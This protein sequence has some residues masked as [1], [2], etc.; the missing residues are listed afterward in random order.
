MFERLT[1]KVAYLRQHYFVKNAAV[2]QSGTVLGN[3]LQAVVGIFLARLL[4]PEL[5]G[6]YVLAFSLAGLISVVFGIGVQEAVL[7]VLG[8]AYQENDRVTAKD[9]LTFMLKIAV[10]DFILVLASLPALLW[11]AQRMYD[12]R[13]IGLYA[14]VVV[15]A[16]VISTAFLSLVSVALQVT[17]QIRTLTFLTVG[18]QILRLVLSVA[19]VL[20][21]LKVA[22]AALGHFWGAVIVAIISLGIWRRISRQDSFFPSIWKLLAHWRKVSVRRLWW[23]YSF[24]VNFDRGIGNLYQILP[25]FML[26]IFMP[27]SEVTFFKLAFGYLNLAL[28]LLAPISVLLNSEFPHTLAEDPTKIRSRFVKVSGYATL[29]SLVITIGAVLFSPIMFKILYGEAFAPSIWYTYGLAVYAGLMGIGVGLGPLWRA[30]R[31]IRTSIV[32]NV[33]TLMVGIPTGYWLIKYWHGWG[34]VVMVTA[35]YTVSH[36]AS[37]LYLLGLTS[38]TSN[39][40]KELVN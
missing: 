16:A 2:L 34:A 28:S 3:L 33:A 11:I 6:I 21:G 5:Y 22:G 10:V 9:F 12:S 20:G 4:Q 13:A 38:T 29:L 32:I 17:R 27:P 24:W 35:W 14:W 40:A 1:D 37:F 8:K 36:F 23:G 31:R 7:A 25:V 39:K 26:G 19:L 15:L 30:L 18:D